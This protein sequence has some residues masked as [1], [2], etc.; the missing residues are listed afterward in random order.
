VERVIDGRESV[1]G[2]G[3]AGMPRWAMHCSTPRTT[4][5]RRR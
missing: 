5:T 4:T 1:P 2:H 3:G